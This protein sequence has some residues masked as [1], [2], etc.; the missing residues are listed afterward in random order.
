MFNMFQLK[1]NA[2]C[3]HLSLQCIFLAEIFFFTFPTYSFSNFAII[4][5]GSMVYKNVADLRI[6][7]TLS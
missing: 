1:I 4:V 6:H 2:L 3:F 7:L 5:Y